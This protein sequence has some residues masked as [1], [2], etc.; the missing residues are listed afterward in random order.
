VTA[1]MTFRAARSFT[2]AL[3]L[4]T[5]SALLG[6]GKET[7][8]AAAPEG[9]PALEFASRIRDYRD[10]LSWANLMVERRLTHDILRDSLALGRQFLVNKQ[11]P[12]GNFNY[13]YDF[14]EKKLD[15]G[16][17][18]VRQAGALWGLAL[19]QQYEGNDASRE[20]LDRGLKFFFENSREGPVKGSAV[21][22]YPG[23]EYCRTGTVALVA[24]AIIDYLRAEAARPGGL[25][26][27]YRDHL[28]NMVKRYLNFLLFMGM[29]DG[30]FSEALDLKTGKRA[31][32]SS[33]YFDGES[34]LC[35]VKAARYLGY[36]EL[37]PAIEFSAMVM[38]KDYTLE[39]WRKDPDSKRTKGFFQWGCMAFWEYQD[40]GWKNAEVFSDCVLSLAWWM[41]YVHRTL[42]RPRNTAYAYEGLIHAYLIARKKGHEPALRD[43][44]SVIDT[45][46][47]KLTSWQVG[48]PLQSG[49]S[50]L[51]ALP[52]LDPPAVGGVMN[53][54]SEA[55][56][57]V[58]V[59]QHQMHAV[60]LALRHLYTGP[61]EEG[62]PL[63]EESLDEAID[64]SARYLEKSTLG[65][66]SF[67]YSTNLNPDVEGEEGYNLLRHAG[68]I[69]AMT[70]YQDLRPG[71]PMAASIMR[72]GK[73]LRDE[74][75]GPVEEIPGALAVW[76]RPEV[77]GTG[78]P[79][80]AK[81]GGTGLGLVALLSIEGMKP[82]FTPLPDLRGLGSF[83]LAMQK[84]D[85]SF[86]SKYVPSR[87]GRQ[88]QW[89]SLY[90]P[91]EAALGLLMLYE[92]D[93]DRRWLLSA[94]RAL[95]YLALSRRDGEEI[96]ADHWALLATEKLLGLRNGRGLPVS[97]E[98]LVSHGEQVCRVILGQQIEESRN[99]LLN[100]GFNEKGRTTPAATRLEGLLAALSFLP[101]EKE[102]Q[103]A[104][105]TALRRG[106]LFL[107][108]AQVAEGEHAGAFPRVTG[109]GGMSASSLADVDASATEMRIDYVQHALSAM[110]RYRQFLDGKAR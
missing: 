76:S 106:I 73:Y 64:R 1:K 78:S 81:L 107:L 21:I 98:L 30:H 109:L 28:E 55:P 42:Q 93:P 77:N 25:E 58:D 89:T 86:T 69:Y 7:R 54:R 52:G 88:D 92:K 105:G 15:E 83:I 51:A 20:A 72:A 103:E 94:A 96:P 14:L 95:E 47:Y 22:A 33:P 17:S 80:T 74:A 61:G 24:L 67:V 71:V 27:G 60:V 66:G 37:L 53:H 11:K 13:Q 85:G 35:L 23:E 3:L 38:A 32:G 62:P 63:L 91:G 29:K 40:A 84:E 56:L 90:Y 5:A 41:I 50:F 36:V 4:L 48:G 39:E 75:T 59:T 65:D 87:G 2:A 99:L 57:R 10:S 45:G 6:T 68:T 108:S 102:L 101:R 44:S 82:G 79:L 100:G 18:Q 70:M 110:I 12:G 43:L 9:A 19:I 46:M 104:V 8:A 26:K 16:D 97:R 49:N 34:L 31:A